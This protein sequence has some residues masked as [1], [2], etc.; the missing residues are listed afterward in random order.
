MVDTVSSTPP[1]QDITNTKETTTAK[2]GQKYECRCSSNEKRKPNDNV[3]TIDCQ[4]YRD[5][6]SAKGTKEKSS[7]SKKA[8]RLLKL[9]KKDKN[10]MSNDTMCKSVSKNG[11]KETKIKI[12]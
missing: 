8:I 9:E 10:K 4:K 2:S 11:R 3:T 5:K 7:A 6:Q 12:I 1:F